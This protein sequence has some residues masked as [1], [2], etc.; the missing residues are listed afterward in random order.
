[1]K[2]IDLSGKRFGKLV[3]LHQHSEKSK[4]GRICWV[5]ICDCGTIRV[6]QGNNLQ[7]GNSKSCGC[8]S[9]R[10]KI[11]LKSKT[12]GISDHHPLYVA[13]INLKHRCFNENDTQYKRYGGR[14]I[15]VYEGWV[16]DF[17]AFYDWS[18]ENG[19]REGLTIDRINND[20]NYEPSNCR[21]VERKV[22]NSNRSSNVWICFEGEH[23]TLQQWST[24]TGIKAPT[25][26][27][28]I[29]SGWSVEDALT[30]L[31]KRSNFQKEGQNE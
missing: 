2:I 30:I 7:S 25:I 28:R 20:G 14:G 13:W 5:C 19:W 11:G 8:E 9:S 1:M 10:R 26:A 22:Q 3:V 18:L 31:P 12:H 29:K 21:W 27:K 4:S 16:H 17:R 15:T 6:I 23:H 24:I